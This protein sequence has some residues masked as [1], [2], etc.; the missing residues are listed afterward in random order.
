MFTKEV[1]ETAKPCDNA[2]RKLGWK[3]K[4]QP[5][6][7]C[8]YKKNGEIALVTD[9]YP[10]TASNKYETV[11]VL[12]PPRENTRVEEFANNFI[13][14]LHWEKIEK[15]LEK[16]GYGI[17]ISSSW[18][19]ALCQIFLTSTG[20][21]RRNV[22]VREGGRTRQEAIIKSVIALAKGK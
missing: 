3:W 9:Y 8:I 6:E 21:G 7:W 1:I 22:I 14:I 17:H 20:K 5:G 18:E 2:L 19:H 15:I 10:K 11:E 16:A 4:P 12:F 13:P